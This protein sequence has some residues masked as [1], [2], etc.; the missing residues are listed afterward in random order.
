MISFLIDGGGGSTCL[1]G[2]GVGGEVLWNP[3]LEC[4]YLDPNYDSN[5]SYLLPRWEV[6]TSPPFMQ[7]MMD[8]IIGQ[9]PSFIEEKKKSIPSETPDSTRAS[10]HDYSLPVDLKFAL[11]FLLPQKSHSLSFYFE[12]KRENI[13]PSGSGQRTCSDIDDESRFPEKPQQEEET[14]SIQCQR[15]L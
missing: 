1:R 12:H 6:P 13:W 14:F 8:V 5:A 4:S 3:S 2:P 9:K 15:R 10:P 7:E 11:V